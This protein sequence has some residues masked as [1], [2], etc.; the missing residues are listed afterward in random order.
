ML[1]LRL[2]LLYLVYLYHVNLQNQKL[3]IFKKV[4][5]Y[6][7][8]CQQESSTI[9]T[10]PLPTDYVPCCLPC[11]CDEKCYSFSDCCPV[12]P[13]MNHSRELNSVTCKHTLYIGRSLSL[14]VST[15]RYL[16]V[17]D[18]P[19][20]EK[21]S[22]ARKCGGDFEETPTPDDIVVVSETKDPS[23]I[24]ANKYCALCNGVKET[25]R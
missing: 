21:S 10:S 22:T 17:Q 1:L 23:R 16:M 2:S 19:G 15:Q 3:E 6:N 13:A 7:S 20:H 11:K 5:P 25:K 12:M 4:C 18:C 8:L 9:D 14:H 24:Y